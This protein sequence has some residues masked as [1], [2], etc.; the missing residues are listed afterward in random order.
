MT[1]GGTTAISAGGSPIY[2]GAHRR[3]VVDSINDH[4]KSSDVI[5]IG[6]DHS[7][8]ETDSETVN[9]RN[10]V[11]Y[12]CNIGGGSHRHHHPAIRHLLARKR[13]PENWVFLVEELWVVMHSLG[14]R[15]NMGR[16]ILGLL[17]LMV[18]VSVFLRF[19]FTVVVGGLREC[20]TRCGRTVVIENGILIVQSFKNGWSNAQK[21]MVDSEA[22]SAEGVQKR[23]MK[24][25]PV[26]LIK[27]I[28]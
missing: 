18:L 5:P 1:N 17:L 15:K 9:N 8:N 16:T 10:G 25:F 23:Q 27:I 7:V 13:V 28:N 26:S 19:S 4:E 3:R 6:F 20:G 14:S 12:L 22:S 24:E 21:A 11:G 2:G